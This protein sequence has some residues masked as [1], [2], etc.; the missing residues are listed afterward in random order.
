M[1]LL[2]MHSAKELDAVPENTHE[3]RTDFYSLSNLSSW[4]MLLIQSPLAFSA[5]PFGLMKTLQLTVQVDCILPCFLRNLAC[6][7]IS[8]FLLVRCSLM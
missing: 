1:V 4:S 8:A 7:A 5:T 2:R 3:H 6:L